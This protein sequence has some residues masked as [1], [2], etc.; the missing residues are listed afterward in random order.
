MPK[1]T[2][3]LLFLLLCGSKSLAVPAPLDEARSMAEVIDLVVK[4][5]NR[6]NQDIRKFSP[7]AET[8]IQDMKADKALGYTPAGDK[9]YLGR[10]N[11]S[12]G[13][14]LDSFIEPDSKG[15]RI[16]TGLGGRFT[17]D[18]HYIPAGFLQ[19]R[20]PRIPR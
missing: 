5:E 13:V 19:I 20:Q 12:K 7:L 15:R 6:F 16:F 10:A 4:N 1:L 8:Y 17:L 3:A 9:Y 14:G 18:I 11:L 2:A